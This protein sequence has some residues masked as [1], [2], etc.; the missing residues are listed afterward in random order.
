MYLENRHTCA[1]SRCGKRIYI[2][3]LE[4]LK[5]FLCILLLYACSSCLCS[6]LLATERPFVRVVFLLSTIRDIFFNVIVGLANTAV[7]GTLWAVLFLA[8]IDLDAL[9]WPTYQ[10]P[11]I[12]TLMDTPNP[13]DTFH[14]SSYLVT[15]L[16]ETYLPP[17]VR[18]RFT[19]F[20]CTPVAYFDT[21]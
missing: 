19:F 20:P 13:C 4:G 14:C 9:W 10:L 6:V 21:H 7:I 3:M 18:S 16:T 11:I 17:H 8:F 12:T 1:N 2:L 5:C 15:R